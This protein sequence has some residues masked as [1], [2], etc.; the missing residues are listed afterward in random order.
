[1]FKCYYITIWVSIINYKCK[2]L[3]DDVCK[4][5]NCLSYT[6]FRGSRRGSTVLY[7]LYRGMHVIPVCEKNHF[8]FRLHVTWNTKTPLVDFTDIL[9]FSSSGHRLSSLSNGGRPKSQ[10]LKSVKIFSET[11]RLRALIFVMWH[12]FLVLYKKDV[13]IMFLWSILAPP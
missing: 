13:Q 11:R 10:K 3:T 8:T 6:W 5:V 12:K 7:T 2:M 9:V 1:M 4:N